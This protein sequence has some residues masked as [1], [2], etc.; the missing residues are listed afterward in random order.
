MNVDYLENMKAIL[1]LIMYSMLCSWHIYIEQRVK[2]KHIFASSSIQAS[3]APF[4]VLT[5]RIILSNNY[6]EG[7]KMQVSLNLIQL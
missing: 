4:K 7:K 2:E 6:I 3:S 5:K 1:F